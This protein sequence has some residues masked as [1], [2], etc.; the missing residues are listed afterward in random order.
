MKEM[1]KMAVY[2]EIIYCNL[3]KLI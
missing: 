1:K 3:Q 2:S